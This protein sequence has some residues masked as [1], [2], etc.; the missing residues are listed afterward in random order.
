MMIS[1]FGEHAEKTGSIFMDDV[2]KEL[3]PI[4][5]LIQRDDF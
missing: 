4:A 5:F 2:Y 3:S 1:A